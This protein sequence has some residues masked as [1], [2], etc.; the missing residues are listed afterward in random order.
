[1]LKAAAPKKD[2]RIALRKAR[3]TTQKRQPELEHVFH[4][5]SIDSDWKIIKAPL[6]QSCL[7]NFKRLLR[8]TLLF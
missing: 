2:A 4:D 1:M 6:P 5:P 8:K 7:L 3:K